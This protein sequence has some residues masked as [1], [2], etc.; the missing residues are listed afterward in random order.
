VGLAFVRRGGV[1]TILSLGSSAN[2]TFLEPELAFCLHG[3]ASSTGVME[4]VCRLQGGM[5]A[6]VLEYAISL[7]SSPSESTQRNT[8]MFWDAAMRFPLVLEAFDKHQGMSK[9]LYLLLPTVK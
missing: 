2:A 3:L 7:L 9:L 6:R 1:E 4:A 8:L 5:F